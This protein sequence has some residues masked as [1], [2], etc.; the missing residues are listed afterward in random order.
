MSFKLFIYYCALCGAWA[1]FLGWMLG[2]FAPNPDTPGKILLQTVLWGL[3]LGLL[4]SAALGAVDAL[5]SASSSQTG[6]VTGRALFIGAVGA[7]AGLVGALVGH[8]LVHLTDK[9]FLRNVFQVIGWTV[10][11]LLIGVSVGLFDFLRGLQKGDK[12]GG[13]MRK[14]INGVIG[15]TLGGLL[16]SI[17]LL[18]ISGVLSRLFNVAANELASTTA[19]GFVALGACIGLFIGLAQVILKEAW[20]RVEAGRR[21]GRELILSKDETTI[22]RAEACDIGLFGDNAIEKLH[23]RI[24]MK[25]NRYLL[26]DAETPSGTYLNDQRIDQATPLR[27]G[28]AIRVGSC[29]LRF[30]EKQ[31]RK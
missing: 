22:G 26:V 12:S 5:W 18:V 1:A 3:L 17:L 25:N 29:V 15:G 2:A 10:C 31:K 7:F 11:G 24:I 13:A 16:G 19:I 30:S 27:S 23:A 28:D 4:V 20:V 14:V 6:R 8:F 21:A 9:V